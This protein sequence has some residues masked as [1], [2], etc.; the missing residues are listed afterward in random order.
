[1]NDAEDNELTDAEY[2]EIEQEQDQLM[3]AFN[4]ADKDDLI[5]LEQY[6]QDPQMDEA[7]IVPTDDDDTDEDLDGIKAVLYQ[8][9]EDVPQETVPE[10]ANDDG[11]VDQN[12]QVGTDTADNVDAPPAAETAN[13]EIEEQSADTAVD[14]SSSASNL[15]E[16]QSYDDVIQE[17][18]ALQKQYNMASKEDLLELEGLLQD[19]NMDVGEVVEDS[20]DEDGVIGALADLAENNE[21]LFYAVS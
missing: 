9:M 18:D 4:M 13:D 1:M 20:Q 3:A 5:A 11:A 21:Q 8:N 14:D 19:D 7:E 17:Q 12:D 15:E 6:L 2:D 16:E 10:E